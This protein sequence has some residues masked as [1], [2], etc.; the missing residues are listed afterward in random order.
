VPAS[1]GAL[2]AGEIRVVA[3]G[4][5][6]QIRIP[7][8]SGPASA[9][10]RARVQSILAFLDAPGLPTEERP[11]L[12]SV[13]VVSLSRETDERRAFT[14][15]VS[16]LEKL[17]KGPAPLDPLYEEINR[18]AQR[19]VPSG[20]EETIAFLTTLARLEGAHAAKSHFLGLLWDRVGE[21]LLETAQALDPSI[22]RTPAGAEGAFFLAVNGS[23]V[24]IQRSFAAGAE[25]R[26][27]D[28]VLED[29]SGSPA[30]RFAAREE[31]EPRGV[32]A[33]ENGAAFF[34]DSGA[35][36]WESGQVVFEGGPVAVVGGELVELRSAIV[37]RPKADGPLFFDRAGSGEDTALERGLRLFEQGDFGGALL[38]FGEAEKAI[39]PA[40][41]YDASDLTYDR[42]RALQEQGKRQEALALFRSIGDVTYQALVDEKAR[43]IESGR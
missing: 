3:R 41:P 42:A 19:V 7:M 32:A 2:P 28:F 37:D 26:H 13:P 6:T 12:A 36:L 23:R 9:E 39:D 5:M 25:L 30:I 35:R 22:R 27:V 18:L 33:L 14:E 31:N 1:A 11:E 24:L 38:A 16:T 29:E 4:G 8:E 15:W 10:I 21:R 20:R 34:F 43:L 40:A 17:E